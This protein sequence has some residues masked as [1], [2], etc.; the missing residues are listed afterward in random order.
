MKIAK[1][2][3]VDILIV[4]VIIACILFIVKFSPYIEIYSKNIN[5]LKGLEFTEGVKRDLIYSQKRLS[6]CSA[7]IALAAL[8]IAACA[9]LF[10]YC[11]PQLFRLSKWTK[12]SEEWAQNKAERLAR[13]QAKAESDKQKRIE[14]LRAELDE[15]NG[16][17]NTN[18]NP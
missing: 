12:L 14:E 1:Q 13:K 17:N 9:F 5:I 15:L 8:S 18:S 4:F 10:V 3:L 2:I 16:D 11:N 7:Y 6:E